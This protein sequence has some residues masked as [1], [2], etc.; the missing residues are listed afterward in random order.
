M[1]SK[2]NTS[3]AVKEN[4]E[5]GYDQLPAIMQVPVRNA[6]MKECGIKSTATFHNKRKAITRITPPEVL[7][8]ESHFKEY[9]I[10]PWTG[11]PFFD[12]K[13]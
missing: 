2:T 5:A 8:I 3:E 9:G 12:D 10:N 11:L 13:F 4:F 1:E 7:I 6:I